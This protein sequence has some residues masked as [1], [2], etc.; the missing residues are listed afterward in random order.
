M[1]EVKGEGKKCSRKCV[2]DKWRIQVN[3]KIEVGQEACELQMK[4]GLIDCQASRFE[5]VQNQ[6]PVCC[7]L[8]IR[9]QEKEAIQ[10]V[11]KPDPPKAQV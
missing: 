7:R 1:S 9:D 6:L 5:S 2:R 3:D 8:G 11:Y 10:V 4:L